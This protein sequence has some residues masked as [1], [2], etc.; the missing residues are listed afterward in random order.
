MTITPDG[1]SRRRDSNGVRVRDRQ[2]SS[3]TR[4]HGPLDRTLSA[5]R[6]VPQTDVAL[7]CAIQSA[8]TSLARY[9][10]ETKIWG[11]QISRFRGSSPEAWLCAL[12]GVH[13]PG[14]GHFV[15]IY[16]VL[17]A[18]LVPQTSNNCYAYTIR[19]KVFTNVLLELSNL[20]SSQRHI[21][22]GSIHVCRIAT[23]LIAAT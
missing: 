22:H 15:I 5:I 1:R 23:T 9:S 4:M 11:C 13:H 16:L 18:K 14:C 21:K 7:R 3:R 6:L 20:G 19:T 12:P 8:K 2:R 10:V 17:V